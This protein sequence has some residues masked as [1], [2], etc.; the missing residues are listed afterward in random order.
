MPRKVMALKNKSSL[1]DGGGCAAVS[2][3]HRYGKPVGLPG[4][5]LAGVGTGDYI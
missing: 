5:G 3:D 1:C 4:M 2:D